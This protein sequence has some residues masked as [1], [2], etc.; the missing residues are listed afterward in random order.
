MHLIKGEILR[1]K[2]KGYYVNKSSLEAWIDGGNMC[3]IS[4][5]M[6]TQGDFENYN[7][8]IQVD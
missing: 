4:E 2:T 8:K 6:I 7:D 3:P 5:E 1:H